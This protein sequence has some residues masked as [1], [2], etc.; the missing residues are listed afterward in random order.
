MSDRK[1]QV[2]VSKDG[3]H[4]WSDWRE[5]S[6]GEVGQ[7]RR[8]CVFRRFGI[9]RQLAIRVRVTSP[10]QASLMGAVAEISGGE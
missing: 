7:Y 6:L 8:R 3:G 2:S 10:V 5:C 4:N 1:V 9:A